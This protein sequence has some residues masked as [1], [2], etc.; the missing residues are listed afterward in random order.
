MITSAGGGYSR[1]RGVAINRWRE[2]ATRD[3]WGMFV[4]LNE[5]ASGE[6]WCATFQPALHSTREY[7]AIFTQSRAEF[8]QHHAGIDLH[9]EIS[10]SPEDDIELRRM[11][12]TNRT[13]V[14][15]VIELTTYFEIVIAAPESDI[16]HPA[17]SNLFVQTEFLRDSSAILATRRARSAEEHPPW[18]L[19]LLLAH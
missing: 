16:T 8:R 13:P 2:D 19:H 1:W 17:F 15:R 3:S 9:T 10:I 6:S 4:Y 12:L 7:E 14:E 11:T 5:E 18:L